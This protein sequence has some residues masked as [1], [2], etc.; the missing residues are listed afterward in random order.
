MYVVLEVNFFLAQSGECNKTTS[1]LS[2]EQLPYLSQKKREIQNKNSVINKKHQIND[3]RGKIT[4]KTC[5]VE[6][7]VLGAVLPTTG[8][9]NAAEG[10]S[11]CSLLKTSQRIIAYLLDF[12]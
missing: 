3:T 11:F 2:N 12:L 5:L 9:P 4:N 7:V 8:L 10:L 6:V 1:S